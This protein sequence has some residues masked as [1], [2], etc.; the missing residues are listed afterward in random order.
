M[1]LIE[2]L[3]K[4]PGLAGLKKENFV[5]FASTMAVLARVGIILSLFVI[6]EFLL[7]VT[8]LGFP[9]LAL[10]SFLLLLLVF[11]L[12]LPLPS[13]VVV[14]DLKGRDHDVYYSHATSQ[15]NARSSECLSICLKLYLYF[16]KFHSKHKAHEDS[17][18]RRVFFKLI[19]GF[20]RIKG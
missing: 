10:S 4:L 9:R 14:E 16:N 7:D 18:S 8:N 1:P 3:K 6:R 2:M 20:K 19:S 5:A 13:L 11:L 12:V 17:K 15:S